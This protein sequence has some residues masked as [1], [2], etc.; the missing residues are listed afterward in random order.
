MLRRWVFVPMSGDRELQ[1]G[2]LNSVRRSTERRRL[3]RST[4]SGRRPRVGKTPRASKGPHT[5]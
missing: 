4:E 1:L 5:S 2:R 3:C